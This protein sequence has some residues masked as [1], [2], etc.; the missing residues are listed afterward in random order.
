MIIDKLDIAFIIK[1]ISELEKLK[2]LLFDEDQ[3]YLFEH[4]P[5]PFLVDVKSALKASLKSEV[6]EETPKIDSKKEFKRRL[7]R[8]ISKQNED[9]FMSSNRFWQ[10][11]RMGEDLKLELF[12]RALNNIKE[13]KELNII[14][15]RLLNILKL[16][17]DQD[18]V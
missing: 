15:K 11:S 18:Q 12:C 13:K 16:Y 5:K 6:D 1:S 14:D 10:K 8:Q 9:V 3:Y 17:S 4:I 7:K 2:L